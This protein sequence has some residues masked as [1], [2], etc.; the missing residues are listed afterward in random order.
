MWSCGHRLPRIM[1]SSI[2][3][4]SRGLS[5]LLLAEHVSAQ[6]SDAVS[7]THEEIHSM[8][9]VAALAMCLSATLFLLMLCVLFTP[10]VIVQRC[11]FTTKREDWPAQTASLPTYEEA[12]FGDPVKFG[13]PSEPASVFPAELCA[14]QCGPPTVHCL[15]LQGPPPYQ[16]HL[17]PSHQME[18]VLCGTVLP[19]ENQCKDI[20]EPPTY[21]DIHATWRGSDSVLLSLEPRC[22]SD[23]VSCS[24]P[25][26]HC[27]S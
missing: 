9:L 12:V 6:Q 26:I 3:I 10:Q 23:P 4:L 24:E 16:T 2:S 22:C 8:P 27:P 21:Q 14:L 11:R 18:M 25:R 5:L 13:L 19:G 1:K 20:E 15:T 7:R 17:G